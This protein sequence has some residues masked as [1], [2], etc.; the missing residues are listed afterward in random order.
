MGVYEI[1]CQ[2]TGK[3]YIGSS[4]NIEQRWQ[5]HLSNLRRKAHHN[6]KLQQAYIRYGENN[7]IFKTLEEV[8]DENLLYE[9]EE[10]HIKRYKFGN[11][12]N[13]LRKP[14]AVPSY[15]SRWMGYCES[16]KERKKE[17]TQDEWVW[18]ND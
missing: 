18:G 3:R 11:L 15:K 7:F 17:A 13:A 5:S 8:Y 10:K 2:K 9:I 1:Y 6:Y 16:K 4:K 14:G 12:F